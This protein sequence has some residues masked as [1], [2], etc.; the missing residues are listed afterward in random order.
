MLETS[1]HSNINVNFDEL[2][3]TSRKT[4]VAKAT[5]AYIAGYV[6]KMLQKHDSCEE[7]RNLLHRSDGNVLLEVI[8]AKSYPKST[9]VQPGGYLYFVVSVVTVIGFFFIGFFDNS[10]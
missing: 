5:L 4:T 6:R 2:P 1:V 3:I 8:Q 7:C 9:L 10:L